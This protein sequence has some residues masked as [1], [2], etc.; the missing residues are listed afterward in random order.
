MSV[1]T[2]AERFWSKVE[3]SDGCWVW[4]AGLNRDGYGRIYRDEQSPAVLAH[5]MAWELENGPIAVGAVICHRCDNP[6]CVRVDHLY[7]GTQADNLADMFSK[8]RDRNGRKTQCKRGHAFDE[9]N[10]R[11]YRGLRVCR[12]C[13]HDR[14]ARRIL[15]MKE[16]A[17]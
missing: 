2:L 10:T 11:L 4:T 6:A 8:R 7:V 9:Q 16:E 1:A 13:E 12:S 5:R 15:S 3:K 17:A 14:Y